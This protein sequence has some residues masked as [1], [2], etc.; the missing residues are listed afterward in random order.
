MKWGEKFIRQE[1]LKDRKKVEIKEISSHEQ[2]LKDIGSKN[3]SFVL[4]Y[5]EGSGISECAIKNITTAGKEINDLCLF[6]VDVSSVKDI[7]E[8][9]AV[10]S[11][12]TLLIFEG[13]KMANTIKGCHDSNYFKSVFESLVPRHNGPGSE[14]RKN[15]VV[16]STPSCSWCATLKIHLRKH[17]IPFRDVDVSR[18]QR[19]AEELV[20]R[21]GQ[22]GVPQTEIDGQI[23]VGF[24]RE[25]INKLLGIEN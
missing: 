11:V 7:H 10:T 14:T 20:R 13:G 25:R 12:P 1:I 15:V 24:D 3:K 4:L 19:I 22:Q 8:R 2:L 16:Y 9:Y 5:K 6:T 21:S 23:I 18:D 17:G